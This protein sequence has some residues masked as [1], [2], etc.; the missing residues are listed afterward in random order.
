MAIGQQSTALSAPA[1]VATLATLVIYI[2]G[3]FLFGAG[4]GPLA[5][6][7]QLNLKRTVVWNLYAIP[8]WFMLVGVVA[9]LV[10]VVVTSASLRAAIREEEAR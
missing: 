6:A 5:A 3:L 7:A 2:S 9:P 4:G 8:A 1:V 10:I